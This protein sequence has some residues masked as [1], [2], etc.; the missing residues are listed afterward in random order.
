ML[1]QR[2]AFDNPKVCFTS[3]TP[4]R[5][6]LKH[7]LRDHKHAHLTKRQF[8]IKINP[9]MATSNVD[10]KPPRTSTKIGHDEDADVRVTT[11]TN[12]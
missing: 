9:T 1:S 8:E 3:K 10:M 5:S 7:G 2:S 12:P 6:E 4:F 11:F